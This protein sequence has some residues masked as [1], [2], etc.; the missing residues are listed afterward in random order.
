VEF[1]QG[2]LHD[3]RAPIQVTRRLATTTSDGR[4]QLIGMVGIEAA[5]DPACRSAQASTLRRTV[6]S[7]ASK[8]HCS[9]G[10][11]SRE[12]TSAPNSP[13]SSAASAFFLSASST[14]FGSFWKRI[15]QIRSL[16]SIN[17]R[18]SSRKRLYSCTWARVCSRAG[19]WGMARVTVFPWNGRVRIQSGSWPRAPRRAQWQLG[20]PRLR[21]RSTREPGRISPRAA[22]WDFRV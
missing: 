3:L 8:S 9:M 2:C 6:I 18:T 19:P 11:P 4:A 10:P 15:S 13:P 20:F 5:L 21:W 14:A 1:P 7:R 17:W 16:T 22:I 12:A